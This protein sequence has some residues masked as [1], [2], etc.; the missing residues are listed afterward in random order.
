MQTIICN[1]TRQRIIR[2]QRLDRARA[3]IRRGVSASPPLHIACAC[4]AL[5]DLSPHSFERRAASSALDSL[6]RRA[7]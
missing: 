7:A 5:I 1:Q 3:I 6:N 2:Q 4:R